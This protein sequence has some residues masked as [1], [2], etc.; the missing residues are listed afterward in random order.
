MKLSCLQENLAKALGIVTRAVPV[1]GPLPILSNVLVATENGRIKLAATDLETTIVTYTGGSIEDE[2]AITVPAKLLKEFVTNLSPST[3]AVHLANDIL[4][5]TSDKTKS[6]FNG[7]TAKDYPELPKFSHEGSIEIDPKVFS[8]AIS[9]VAFASGNDESRPVFT[10]VYLDVKDGK[11]TIAATDGFRLS[12]K[13]I[14]VKGQKKDFSVIIPAKTLLEVSRIFSNSEEPIKFGLSEKE[15]MAVFSSGD[16]FIATRVLDGQY[17]DYK[18]IIPTET[19]LAV[20]FPSADFLEAVKLTNIFAKEGAG[21]I[22]LVFDPEGKIKISSLSGETGEHES[23]IDAEVEGQLTEVAFSSKYLLDFL[24]NVKS[25]KM[26]F[27]TNGSLTP[28]ILKSEDHG[29]FIHI[30]MP[31]Q[32]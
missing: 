30:I 28:C 21:P 5:V 15:N 22:K 31:V 25:E 19:S 4:H 24:N 29:D 23:N 11:I 7:I 16:T 32:I 18:R 26:H 9:V 20:N 3:L 27:H 8:H 2:G 13:V 1:K 10:G 17:P 14:E 6:K 12:E